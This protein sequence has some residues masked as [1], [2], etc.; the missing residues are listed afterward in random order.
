DEAHAE[1]RVAQTIERAVTF[2]SRAEET[3]QSS[4][5]GVGLQMACRQRWFTFTLLACAVDD[6]AALRAFSRLCAVAAP[7][8]TPDCV[9]SQSFSWR[10]LRCFRFVALDEVVSRCVPTRPKRRHE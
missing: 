3:Q 9:E 4:H 7:A 5:H 8:G 1:A 10:R 6:A 2:R